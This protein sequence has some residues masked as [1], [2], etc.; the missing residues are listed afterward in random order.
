M[1]LRAP[2]IA[3]EHVCV[4]PPLYD[5]NTHD[6][7]VAYA[8]SLP[9]RSGFRPAFIRRVRAQYGDAAAEALIE[10]CKRK[11]ENIRDK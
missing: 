8:L 6:D 2:S 9:P 7:R 5:W 11:V 10:D 4:M 3:F 1:S